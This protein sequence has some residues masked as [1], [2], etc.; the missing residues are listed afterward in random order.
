MSRHEISEAHGVLEN[1]QTLP[2]R[3]I[4]TYGAGLVVPAAILLVIWPQL[5]A[6]LFRFWLRK[7][8]IHAPRDVLLVGAAAIFN[9]RKLRPPDRTLLRCDIVYTCLSHL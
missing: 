7:C 4:L 1:I 9:A 6:N 5:A 2:Y 8:V 3:Q